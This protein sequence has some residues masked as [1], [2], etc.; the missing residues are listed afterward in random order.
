MAFDQHCNTNLERVL[1]VEVERDDRRRIIAIEQDV[2]VLLAVH[3]GQGGIGIG[4][5]PDR[6]R[7]YDKRNRR[8][9]RE[10]NLVKKREQP[11]ERERVYTELEE[12]QLQ[13]L[14]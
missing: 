8:E 9:T 6:R 1:E 3:S 12:L 11:G 7:R 10:T 4:I 2:R 13:G 5:V 14:T